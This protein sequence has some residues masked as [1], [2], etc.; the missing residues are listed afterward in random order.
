MEAF[1]NN[2]VGFHTGTVYEDINT[3]L[4]SFDSINTSKGY[5]YNLRTFYMWFKG[6]PLEMLNKDD[7]HI[8]NADM[9]KYRKYLEG[10]EADYSNGTINRMI[11]AIQ[12]LYVFL[13]TND[14]DVKSAVTKIKKL[15]DDS[16]RSGFFHASEIEQIPSILMGTVKGFEKTMLVK[17][18]WTTSFRKASLLSIEW[19]DIVSNEDTGNYKVTTIGKGGKK[20]SVDIPVELYEELLHMKEIDY[21]AK[22]QDNKVFH[23][24]TTTIQAMMDYIKTKLNISDARNIVFHSF[25]NFASMFGTLEE[26][27][28]HYNHSSIVVANKYYGRDEKNKSSDIGLRISDKIEDSIFEEL[29]KDQLIA[30]IMGQHEGSVFQMKRDARRMVR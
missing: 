13:E 30:L 20:H 7:L 6:K 16:E 25:R 5:E 8:R 27:K 15:S 3:F 26:L 24:S 11:A 22:Y 21:Y 10:H 9:L 14:Y 4:N 23:L 17:M 18:A 28:K 1:A 29:S 2:I 12:S 19:D